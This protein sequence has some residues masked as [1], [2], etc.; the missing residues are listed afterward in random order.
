MNR[1]QPYDI[2]SISG[3][4]AMSNT[5]KVEAAVDGGRDPVTH[6]KL[7]TLGCTAHGFL[8]GHVYIQGTTNYD[9]MRKIYSVATN[10]ITIVAPYVAE[11]PGGTETVK[12]MISFNHPIEFLGVQLALSAAGGA[13]E[14]FQAIVDAAAGAAFDT[15]YH[16]TA[17]MT[18][19][20]YVDDFFDGPK[21]LKANDK[22]DFTYANTNSRTWGLKIFTRRLA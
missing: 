17:D 20:K 15:R 1:N 13:N 18:S 8:T 6:E 19:I 21:P 12:S 9:G 10:S 16:N 2:W 11:T 4:K 5:L 7:T 3:A 14:A 22:L